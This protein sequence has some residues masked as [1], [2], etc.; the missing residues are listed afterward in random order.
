MGASFNNQTSNSPN[1]SQ[2]LALQVQA[3][4]QQVPDVVFNNDRV[5]SNPV[6]ISVDSEDSNSI[7][8][9][10]SDSKDN[11]LKERL[12]VD[13]STIPLINIMVDIGDSS[14]K[15][16]KNDEKLRGKMISMNRMHL[17]LFAE[18]NKL[19]VREMELNKILKLLDVCTIGAFNHHH[20][21]QPLSLQ[22]LGEQIDSKTSEKSPSSTAT[23]PAMQSSAMPTSNEIIFHQKLLQWIQTLESFQV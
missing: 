8:E 14:T 19:K 6:D 2:P 5:V 23:S 10:K 4:P 17:D 16:Q 9:L 15:H 7:Y 22:S 1:I 13:P 12:F 18:Q 20:Q 11:S 21:Q 3:P